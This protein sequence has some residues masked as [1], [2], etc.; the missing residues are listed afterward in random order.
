MVIEVEGGIG[1]ADKTDEEKGGGVGKMLTLD[2]K[3]WG[4]VGEVLT[5]ADKGGRRFLDP[6]IFG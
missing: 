1:Y 2:D 4:L 5:L 6:P 3:G